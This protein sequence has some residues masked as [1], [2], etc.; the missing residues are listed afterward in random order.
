MRDEAKTPEEKAK[1]ELKNL[2][3]RIIH[4][5][6]GSVRARQLLLTL[7][8]RRGTNVFSDQDIDEICS[9]IAIHDVPSINICIPGDAKIAVAFREAD[10]LWMLTPAGVKADLVR[11]GIHRPNH[12]ECIKQVEN[13]LKSYRKERDLYCSSSEKF[14]DDCTFFRTSTGY[15]RFIELY[16]NWKKDIE[17]AT[18]H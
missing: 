16:Q 1:L 10:R 14:H 12:G 7:N 3:N 13:N 6:V 11:S 5:G 15:H 17:S 2:E 4:M 18:E 9:V 8:E